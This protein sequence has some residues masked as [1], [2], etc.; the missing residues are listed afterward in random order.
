MFSVAGLFGASMGV[1]LVTKAN[2]LARRPGFSSTLK[3]FSFFLL[4]LI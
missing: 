4:K 2:Q 1:Y 3:Y